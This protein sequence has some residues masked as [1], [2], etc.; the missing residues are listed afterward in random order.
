MNP[1]YVH[2]HRADEGS[3][4][5]AATVERRGKIAGK[6]I[7][8]IAIEEGV[9]HSCVIPDDLEASAVYDFVARDFEECDDTLDGDMNAHED[10]RE[11]AAVKRSA[12]VRAEERANADRPSR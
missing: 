3:D 11:M 12:R 4:E 8:M 2:T 10:K 5:D 9:S 7:A 1:K 6:L